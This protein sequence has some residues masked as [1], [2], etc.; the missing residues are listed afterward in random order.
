MVACSF[1]IF[2]QLNQ[3]SALQLSK[4]ADAAAESKAICST[5]PVESCLKD[6]YVFSAKWERAALDVCGSLTS[7]RLSQQL[8]GATAQ[9]YSS[10]VCICHSF[11]AAALSFEKT[12][13]GRKQAVSQITF[14]SVCVFDVI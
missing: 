10:L 3:L 9:A 13:L 5:V 11:V 4:P 6:C 1:F 14:M 8:R 2:S 7:W 12:I